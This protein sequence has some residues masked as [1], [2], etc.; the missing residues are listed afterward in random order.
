MEC[1]LNKMG[2]ND[3]V[4]VVAATA[5]GGAENRESSP[6][7]RMGTSIFCPVG[8]PPEETQ[9]AAFLGA[10]WNKVESSRSREHFPCRA[11]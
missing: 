10:S 1:Q 3:P 2:Q 5:V 9:N 7:M 4:V 11:R 6:T 8:E